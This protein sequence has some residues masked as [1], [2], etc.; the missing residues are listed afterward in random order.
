MKKILVALMLITPAYGCG[1]KTVHRVVATQHSTLSV[2]Q[3]FQDAEIAEYQKGFVPA[4]AH[5]KM[6]STVQKVAL[7]FKDLDNALASN[8]N[9]PTI[10]AKL[11]NL[12]AL[13]DS[14]NSDGLFFVKDPTAKASLEVALDAVKAIIDNALTEVQ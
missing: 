10:K 6:Q 1:P 7:G 5:L 9:A 13:A 4:D 12:Y 11:D 3:A 14:L 2:V 8:A